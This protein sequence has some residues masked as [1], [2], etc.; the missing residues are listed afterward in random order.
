[1]FITGINA[2][3][4]T[5]TMAFPLGSLALV[6]ENNAPVRI[7]MYVQSAAAISAGTV[8]R[9]SGGTETAGHQAVAVTTAN[10]AGGSG[11]GQLVGVAVASFGLNDY[12]WMLVFGSVPITALASCAAST[13]LNTTATAGALDDDATAGA[14]VIDGI[15]LRSANGGATANT[16]AFVSWARVG[17]TL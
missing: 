8:C 9:I 12:G 6:K 3:D 11:Q 5:S 16:N 1:M 14:R 7:Y 13:Q 2:A 10:T 4:R 15:T 17:R